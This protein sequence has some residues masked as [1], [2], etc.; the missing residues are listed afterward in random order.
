[1]RNYLLIC[2]IGIALFLTSCRKDF[3]FER[4]TGD[5]EFSKET[6][7]LD[8]VF[9]NI[10]SSTYTL[11]VYNRSNKDILIPSIQLEQGNE[12]KYRLMVD[13]MPGKIFSNVE[14]L[15]KDSMFIFIETTIDYEEYQNNETTFLYTD[16]IVFDTDPYT[17]KVEL[18]T[19]V[20]DAVF[21]K[22]NRTL[23]NRVKETLSINGMD[24]DI[25]GH[26]LATAEELHWTNQKPYVIYG[27]ALVPNG[28]TLQVDAG[29]RVHF[30]AESGLI[31]DNSAT[32]EINGQASFTESLENEVIFEGDR[33]EYDFSEIPGQWGSIFLMSG[34]ENTINHLTLKNATVGILMQRVAEN[35]TPK[36][37]LKNIQIYN[38]SNFGILAR[39]S[40]INGENVVI[41]KAGQA[42]LALTLGGTY[43][44]K[45]STIAN[46]FNRPN[47]VPLVLNDYQQ[48][49][50]A[51]LVSNM[52][53]QF[54]NCIFYGNSSLGISIDNQGGDSTQF[55]YSFS[56]CLIKFIDYSNRLKGNFP[57]NFEDTAHYTNCIIAE[58]NSTNQPNFIA[59]NLNN[60]NIKAPSA[61]IENGDPAIAAQVPLDLNGTSRNINLPDI[62]AYQNINEE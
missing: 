22:P 58:S 11:K 44:F 39:T 51:L 37:T 42:A 18:V 17:Q 38:C 62:G 4:S 35:T 2:F 25:E 48:T 12:S 27:Y 56:H 43:N 13:G 28:K 7:Y 19:L 54:H 10:G 20:Q 57:Y 31:I 61:A 53:A 47:Q 33:L 23:P 36:L 15:A 46:Y 59:P 14:V 8:T 3:E 52:D 30:H 60:L 9:T 32:L 40:V 49:P 29:A 26:E 5:L 50:D 16:N 55:N 45:H 6:V 41:N 1:M 24:S 34:S 21:I